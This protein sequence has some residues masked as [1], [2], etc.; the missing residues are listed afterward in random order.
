MGKP[1]ETGLDDIWGQRVDRVAGFSTRIGP[2]HL[3]VCVPVHGDEVIGEASAEGQAVTGNST[4]LDHLHPPYDSK[5]SGDATSHCVSLHGDEVIGEASA[6]GK[7]IAGNGTCL[8]H[9]HPLCDSKI[10]GVATWHCFLV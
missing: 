7:A 2:L 6:E 5:V 10:S 4:R 3:Q 9:L 1:T 8:D